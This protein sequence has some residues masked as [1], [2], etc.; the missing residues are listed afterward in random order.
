[1]ATGTVKKLV[2]DRGFGFIEPSEGGEQL[3]FHS[4]ALAP[5]DFDL[6]QTDQSLEYEVQPDPR[7]AGRSRAVNVRV[8][9]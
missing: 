5:G 1:M 4:S 9:G 2:K 8:A 3:F 7:N 6:L